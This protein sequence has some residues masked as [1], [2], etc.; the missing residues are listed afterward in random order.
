MDSPGSIA[1]NLRHSP[2]QSLDIDRAPY[3][4][5]DNMDDNIDEEVD[6]DI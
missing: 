6:V 5:I 2:A 3:R 1:R 4:Y